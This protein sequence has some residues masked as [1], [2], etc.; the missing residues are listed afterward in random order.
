MRLGK[1]I[2][3][4][5]LSL[6]VPSLEG[7]RWLVVSPLTRQFFQNGTDAPQGMSR[8]PTLIVYDSL[9]GGVGDTIG[10]IE[11]REAA[12]PFTEPTP[13]DAYNGALITEVFYQPKT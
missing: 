7:G 6:A 10:F 4:V 9:G 12:V 11:G 2:G 3:R 1:V 8:E 5:T 13:I